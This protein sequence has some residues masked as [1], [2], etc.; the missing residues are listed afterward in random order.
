M[1][2]VT[3]LLI[4]THTPYLGHVRIQRLISH[5]G[6]ALQTFRAIHESNSGSFPIKLRKESIEFIS[7][8][9]RQQSWQQDLERVLQEGIQLLPIT[10]PLFP[11]KLR[12][13]HN[14]PSLLYLKGQFPDP[15]QPA[16]GI[17]G[18]RSS[19]YTGNDQAL[20]FAKTLSQ[21]GCTIISGLARGIDTYAHQ[22]S[23]AGKNGLTLA[24][25]GSGLGQIYPQENIGLANAISQNGAIISELPYQEPPSRFTFP[26]RN[27]IIAGLSDILL[28]IEA[29]QKSG[30]M[31]TMEIGHKQKKPL[32]ALPG[33]AGSLTC[34]GNH[35]L[36]KQRIAQLIDNPDEILYL[37][38]KKQT[39]ASTPRALNIP[40]ILNPDEQKIIDQLQEGDISLEE[41]AGRISLPIAALQAQL[42]KLILRK[43][44]LELP[45]K[46]YKLLSP[47]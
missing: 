41:L 11:K 3:S 8:F 46:R 32:F 33:K 38:G 26:Q 36:I 9:E 20:H 7:T 25:I 43:F 1:D 31:I 30:A 23:L 15:K 37:F 16:I 24:V 35:F 5:F 14:A 47:L 28:L 45:G 19:S 17:I 12:L 22:G 29:P 42:V 6:S 2:E 4:L 21:A 40:S 39:A 44:I 34:A 27:R 13:I 10:S 18:T